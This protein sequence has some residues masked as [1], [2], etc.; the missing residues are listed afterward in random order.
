MRRGFSVIELM[1]AL[2][3]LGLVLALVVRS[4]V[5]HERFQRATAAARERARAAGQAASIV[6]AMLSSVSLGDFVASG[7]AD[8]ALD[9]GALVGSGIGCLSGTLL[10][11]GDGSTAGQPAAFLGTPRAGDTVL[12]FDE[13]R[14]PPRWAA[15]ALTSVDAGGAPCP[16]LGDA[17]IQTLR[18]DG[19]LDVGPTVAFRVLRRTRLSLY[20]SGDG[21]WYLGMRDWNSRAGTFNAVQ[22]VAGPLA[23]YQ[24]DQTRTGLHFEFL[25]S[26]GRTVSIARALAGEARA[27]HVVTRAAGGS[28][29]AIRL[30]GLDRAH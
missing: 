2:V 11:I 5:F 28:D 24:R 14:R 19:A 17:A 20:R 15:T 25:D 1:T 26:L 8:S 29:S 4:A 21:A 10:R 22:P 16:L 30:I 3:V 13:A 27:L 7:V 12:V 18:L 23:S 6:N 9:L